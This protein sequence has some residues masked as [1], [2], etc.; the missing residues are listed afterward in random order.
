MKKNILLFAAAVM[1]LASCGRKVEFEHMTFATF[2]STSYSFNE[3]VEEV[4]IPVTIV[5]PTGAEFS[6]SV[7]TIDGKAV[8]GVDYEII[9]PV[10][11]VLTFGADETT[12]EIVIGINYDD[13]RTGTKDFELS[14]ASATEGFI[15]GGSNI[16]KLRIKDDNHP[17]K[18]FIGEWNARAVGYSGLTYSWSMLIEGDE[19]DPT[20]SNLL[21]YDLDPLAAY[22]G[23]DSANGYNTVDA[24]ANE[25]K[26]QLTIVQDSYT[27]TDEEG[28]IFDAPGVVLSIACLS[29]PTYVDGG[30]RLADVKM[31]LSE[32]GSTLTIPNALAILADGGLAEIVDGPLVFTKK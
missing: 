26:N 30:S 6:V 25:A 17:L 22:F 3:D 31:E 18:M 1:A 11:G 23:Y 5:N 14:I 12:Q 16:A 19:S 15:V 32:D 21:V 2:D 8:E 28:L 24:K 27:A 20:W 10:S 7:K 13:A 29:T 4:K 9:S